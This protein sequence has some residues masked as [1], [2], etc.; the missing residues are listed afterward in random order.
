MP[1]TSRTVRPRSTKYISV[2]E[3]FSTLWF[4]IKLVCDVFCLRT[5]GSGA[6][7][8]GG[9]EPSYNNRIKHIDSHLVSFVNRTIQDTCNLLQVLSAAYLIICS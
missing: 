4:D 2:F 5:A 9:E 7:A 1:T 3:C 6:I 8:A